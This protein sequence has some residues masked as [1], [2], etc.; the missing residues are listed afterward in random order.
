MSQTQFES[1]LEMSAN[2][3]LKPQFEAVQSDNVI[4]KPAE[5]LKP[6]ILLVVD[7]GEGLKAAEDLLQKQMRIQL[8]LLG[9][10]ISQKTC[11]MENIY[12]MRRALY[13]IE[14]V[15]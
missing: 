11:F 15:L 1:I 7:K 12:Q 9:T 3:G 5:D 8:L 6:F 13:I 14:K 10:R 2:D 4:D